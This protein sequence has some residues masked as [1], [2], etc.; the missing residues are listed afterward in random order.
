MLLKELGSETKTTCRA[1][2][3][4]ARQ[5]AHSVNFYSYFSLGVA[6]FFSL[7]FLIAPLLHLFENR[8]DAFVRQVGLDSMSVMI[9][10]LGFFLLSAFLG[11]HR[12]LSAI[13]KGTSIG[14]KSE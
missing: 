11:L 4:Q 12:R 10:L 13:E 1:M 3:V 7:F 6:L 9:G 8:A 5:E 14:K 2:R